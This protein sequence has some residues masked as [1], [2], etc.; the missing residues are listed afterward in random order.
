MEVWRAEQSLGLT[1]NG[2]TLDSDVGA[3]QYL[4]NTEN[5]VD[6]S[7]YHNVIMGMREQMLTLQDELTERD[8]QISELRTQ[9]ESILANAS[10]IRIEAERDLDASDAELSEPQVSAFVGMF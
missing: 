1:Q 6:M 10:M 7:D 8:R 9:G 3:S 4:H 2:V 5:T